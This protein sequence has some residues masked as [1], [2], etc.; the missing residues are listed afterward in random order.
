MN[1]YSFVFVCMLLIGSLQIFAQS[2]STSI[3][4][5]KLPETTKPLSS[6]NPFSPTIGLGV[7]N[8][9]FYGDV[10]DANVGTPFISNLA[11][12]LHIKQR[13]N[14]YLALKFYVLFGKVSANERSLDRNLNFESRL[15][16]GGFALM[17]DFGNFLPKK[18]SLSPFLSLGIESV[19]F[20]SKT[21]LYDEFGNRYNYWSDGSIRNISQ[22][23]PNA[24]EAIVIQ[25]DYVFETDIRESDF[26]GL[27]KYPERTFAIP[28]GGGVI[29]HATENID[30]TLGFIMHFT[31]S[32]LVDGVVAESE[33]DRIGSQPGNGSN[34]KFLMSSFSISYNFLKHQKNYEIKDF[35]APIDYLAYDMDDEDGDGVIDFMDECAWTPPGVEVDEKGC[36][37]DMD[38]D[39]VPNYKDDELESRPNAFVTPAGVEMTDDMIKDAYLRYMDTTGAFATIENRSITAGEKSK[40]QPKK[41]KIQLG[42]FTEAIDAALVDKFLSVSDVDIQEKD[43]ETIITVGDYMSLNEAVQRK[44]SL[45]RD[46]FDAA[47]VVE[48]TKDGKLVSVGDEANN[49]AVGDEFASMDNT[50]KVVFRVQLGAFSKKQPKEQFNKLDGVIELKADDGLYKYLA[51]GAYTTIEE[52][53]K[54]KINLALD[55]GIKDAFVVA[56]QGGK[57]ITLKQAGVLSAAQESIKPNA[58]T[59]DKNKIVFKIQIGSYKNQ[60]PVEVLTKFMSI[61]GV[62]Q[63]QIENDLTRYTTGTFKTYDEAQAYKTTITEEKGIKGAFVIALHGD[64]LIP[65]NQARELLGE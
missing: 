32:D 46:G 18:R 16:V 25:R 14:H 23:D 60:L 6:I 17:Y 64:E 15:S 65:V 27:G 29:M 7:G 24:K 12:D 43:G 28:F 20:H 44:A 26:D 3:T 55:N 10:L 9:K 48:E 41:Y 1:K 52:A 8:F 63:T 35:D 11:Y 59:Y 49:M 19:E 34:D 13:L 37:L 4:P 36:P 21:D 39:F 50:D 58:K 30:F 62:E 45:T 57:R 51:P 40:I 31:F 2:D 33:G 5:S 38:K 42:R 47:I 56:Y 61:K 53:A 22:D 54:Q